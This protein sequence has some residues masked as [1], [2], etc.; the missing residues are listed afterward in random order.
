M[1]MLTVCKEKSGGRESRGL[2]CRQKINPEELVSAKNRPIPRMQGDLFDLLPATAFLLPVKPK[3][4]VFASGSKSLF[5]LLTAVNPAKRTD[6]TMILC[7]GG[8]RVL[9]KGDAYHEW[10]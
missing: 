3:Q 8:L 7:G 6:V 10:S 5:Q 1:E 4:G 9:W 2:N